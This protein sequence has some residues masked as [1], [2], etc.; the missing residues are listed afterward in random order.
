MLMS[1][2]RDAK[3]GAGISKSSSSNKGSEIHSF[4]R[5]NNIDQNAADALLSAE[6]WLQD[7]VLEKGLRGARNPSGLLMAHIREGKQIGPV[8]AA[9]E[10]LAASGAIVPAGRGRDDRGRDRDD[11]DKKKKRKRVKRKRSRSS[12]S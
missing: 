4:L 8:R 5:D 9:R 12:S 2:L 3:A 6:P 11:R 1:L 7:F 10:R